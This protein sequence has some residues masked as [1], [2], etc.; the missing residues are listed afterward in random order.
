MRL[1]EIISG[2][3]FLH[4]IDFTKSTHISWVNTTGPRGN[5]I[6]SGRLNISGTAYEI[7][8][9]DFTPDIRKLLPDF[10]HTVYSVQFVYEDDNGNLE[11]ST[12]NKGNGIEVFSYIFNGIKEG[13]H[14]LPAIP[15]ILVASAST[16][17]NTP[18]QLVTRAKI[19]DR[20]MKKIKMDASY[21][22][23]D[24][25]PV[26]DATAVSTLITSVPLDISLKQQIARL[27]RAKR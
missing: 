9:V 12:S 21:G 25:M 10:K 4:E 27:C 5:H 22:Y 11:Q 26:R 6:L 14:K 15:N 3:K 8:F 19:Y 7:S 1:N 2:F 20:I 24:I 23:V 18:E 16:K 17:L 13:L